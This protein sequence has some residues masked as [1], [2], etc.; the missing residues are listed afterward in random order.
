MPDEQRHTSA[1]REPLAR[2]VIAYLRHNRLDT[3]Q[4]GTLISTV[5]QMLGHLGEPTKTV[6]AR[7]W[8]GEAADSS[9]RLHGLPGM[10]A[11][12]PDAE[13]T[14]CDPRFIPNPDEYNP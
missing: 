9:S 11:S 6:I 7:P 4:I 10:W 1:N 12:G 2:I 3:G 8:P 14:P 5:H 13:A